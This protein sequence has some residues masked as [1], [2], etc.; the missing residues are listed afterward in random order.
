MLGMLGDPIKI[1]EGA[2]NSFQGSIALRW[3]GIVRYMVPYIHHPPGCCLLA[4]ILRDRPYQKMHSRSL[5]DFL[6]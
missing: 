2:S 4:I 6:T 5:R 3:A 1:I